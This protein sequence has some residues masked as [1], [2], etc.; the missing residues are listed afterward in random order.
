MQ[1]EGTSKG[2]QIIKTGGKRLSRFVCASAFEKYRFGQLRPLQCGQSPYLTPA[3]AKATTRLH[4]CV[5]KGHTTSS[6]LLYLT[7]RHI[8]YS[9]SSWSSE[10]RRLLPNVHV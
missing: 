7:P 9:S 3:D 6:I 1:L 10:F 2:H 8:P 5:L 4:V